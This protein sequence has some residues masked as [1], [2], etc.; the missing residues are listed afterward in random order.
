MKFKRYD[1]L[2]K[3]ALWALSERNSKTP[4]ISCNIIEIF[5]SFSRETALI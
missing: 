3:L 4:L 5:A 2:F 1:L